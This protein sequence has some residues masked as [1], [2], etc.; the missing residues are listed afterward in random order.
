MLSAIELTREL[1]FAVREMVAAD[2]WGKRAC[3]KI[4]GPKVL[5][6]YSDSS[7]AILIVSRA[8]KSLSQVAEGRLID[9]PSLNSNLPLHAGTV[10][11]YI[12]WNISIGSLES[13]D[14][15]LGRYV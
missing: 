2:M 5:M 1:M 11:Q 4:K 6:R 10:D 9:I 7:A 8:S 13:P 3:V 15:I 12:D 14:G